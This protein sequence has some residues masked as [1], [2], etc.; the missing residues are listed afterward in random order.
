M[1]FFWHFGLDINF[2]PEIVNEG[3]QL[4][5]GQFMKERTERLCTPW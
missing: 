3:Q 5:T 1:F 4:R 2:E